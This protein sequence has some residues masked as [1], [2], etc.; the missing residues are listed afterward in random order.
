MIIID[1]CGSVH[2]LQ[3]TWIRVYIVCCRYNRDSLKV[4]ATVGEPINPEAW[5]WYYNVVGNKKTAVVDTF[6]QTETVP[7]LL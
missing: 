6:W 7:S 1:S 4:I 2:C 3:N 5:L